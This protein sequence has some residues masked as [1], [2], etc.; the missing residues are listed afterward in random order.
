M[1]NIFYL[2]ST[3]SEIFSILEKYKNRVAFLIDENGVLKGSLTDGDLRR[4]ILNTGEVDSKTSAQKL[5]NTDV[6][7]IEEK[8]VDKLPING[9]L[10]KFGEIP[11]VNES[12]EIIRILCRERS[13]FSLG[14]K[15][16]TDS[17]EPFVIAEIGNNHQGDFDTAIALIKA[18]NEAGADCA[19]FQMRTMSSLYRKTEKSNDLGA[20]YTL[21]LLSKFQLSDEDLFKCFDY[22]KELGMMPLC[23]PWDIKSLSKLEKYGMQGYKVA[24]ADFTNYELLEALINTGKPL[25]ISTG[26][27]T[28]LECI[29]T[30]EFLNKRTSNYILLHCNSTYPTPFK[31]V[32]LKYL[33]KLRNISR[34]PVG[35]SGHER[36]TAVAIA[37]AALGA[38]VIEKHFTFD[39]E[40][41]GNDHKVSLLPQEFKAMVQGIKEVSKSLGTSIERTLTQGELINRENLAKSIIA[42][43]EIKIGEIFSEEM[44]VFRSPGQGLQPNRLFEL[45]GKKSQRFIEEGDFLFQSDID[46]KESGFNHFSFE[47]PFGVPVR[48]GDYKKMKSLSNIDFVE[49]HLSYQ[50]LEIKDPIK[51]FNNFGYSVH[52]PELFADDHLLDLASLDENYRKLS[53]IYL[54]KTIECARKLRK[55]FVQEEDPILI[56]NVG[57]W[58]RKRFLSKSVIKRKTEILKESL[59]MIDFSGVELSIQ[60]MPPFPWHFGGQQFH[61]LFVNPDFINSFCSETGLK[62]CLDVSH[63]M[64]TCNYLDIEFMSDY[65][66]KV[67]NHVNYMHIVD[68]KGV[69]GE[70]VQIGSGDVPF[71]ELCVELN[72]NLPK[73]AFVPEVWQGHKDSGN[74]FWNALSYLGTVGLK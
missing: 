5:M 48:Y 36:G 13:F 14:D 29:Q 67:K 58:S 56:V 59:K 66:P 9:L 47:R 25:I 38:V 2:K 57:G 54:N 68:A 22:C 15:W 4:F 61:N 27:S 1:N 37:A 65:Y 62:I 39:K 72:K 32:N 33:E 34:S 52:A 16:N 64:M 8:S 50:D 18:A 10:E 41:E 35:Y 19:K 28:E 45:I 63:S 53:I 7:F 17:G 74:G 21:D 30:I 51:E 71:K 73:V 43:R 40:Q 20:E 12:K 23:T 11:I 3:I 46:E 55:Y 24:S 49:F 60:T 6:F 31:D 42:K 26:M 70:G 44:F 69:D